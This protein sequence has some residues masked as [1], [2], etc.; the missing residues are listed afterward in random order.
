MHRDEETAE[1]TTPLDYLYRVSAAVHALDAGVTEDELLRTACEALIDGAIFQG[2]WIG[3]PQTD[4]TIE[5]RATAGLYMS[6]YLASAHIRLDDTPEGRGPVGRAWRAQEP[7][8]VSD[9]TRD[10]QMIPWL[11]A[12]DRSGGWRS[13]AAF[14]LYR[15]GTLWGI[16]A[17]YASRAG[18]FDSRTAVL[19]RLTADVLGRELDWRAASSRARLHSAFY[20]SLAQLGELVSSTDRSSDGDFFDSVC[21]VLISTELFQA[22]WISELEADNLFHVRAVRGPGEEL[23][24]KARFGPD[25]DPELLAAQAW[26]D[27]TSVW[28]NAY[29]E[30]PDLQDGLR[31]W[32]KQLEPFGWQSIATAP[33][34]RHGHPWGLLTVVAASGVRFGPPSARLLER[35]AKQTGHALDYRDHVD[36]LAESKAFYAALARASDAVRHHVE[37]GEEAG[38]VEGFCQAV[39]NS[40]LFTCIAVGV[41][42]GDGAI[43]VRNSSGEGAELLRAHR[44]SPEDPVGRIAAAAWREGRLVFCRDIRTEPSLE[45]YRGKLMQVGWGGYASLPVYRRGERWGVVMV[46][47]RRT[48]DLGDEAV[49]LFERLAALL[50]DGLTEIDERWSMQKARERDQWLATHDAL[51]GIANRSV[52]DSMLPKAIARARRGKTMVAVAYLDLDGFKEINDN[53]GHNLGDE[54]LR[55]I[56]QRAVTSVREID[57]LVRW[58][59]D[60]FL[61]IIEGLETTE[62][63]AIPIERLLSAISSPTLIAGHEF[64]VRSSCGVAFYPRDADS[65]DTLIR[66]ADLALYVHKSRKADPQRPLFGH[67]SSDVGGQ[68]H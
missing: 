62:E 10:Q 4:G 17:V 29:L 45:P 3:T 40:A 16:W 26:R 32:R 41:A 59:G 65:T 58:G 67:Y 9:W 36:A 5:Y 51:T 38:L 6:D 8:V 18:T 12:A 50:G 49:L 11:G 48:R 30:D 46:A 7:V 37:R 53:Q 33:I 52:T 55:R 47:F 31:R 35:L 57:T 27:G 42:G 19:G 56:A 24:R 60:E 28:T 44:L 14:P 23:V 64:N 54:L 43:S 63:V 25:T 15:D 21:T 39:T 20:Q 1:E 2:C 68:T 22:A 34:L 66:C 61:C 13:T